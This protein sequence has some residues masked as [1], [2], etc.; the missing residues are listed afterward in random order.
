MAP[1]RYRRIPLRLTRLT[2]LCIAR[3][4]YQYGRSH[5][6]I[7]DWVGGSMIPYTSPNDP[8]FFFHHSQIEK[9]FSTWQ[10]NTN[11]FGSCYRPQ[12][13]DTTVNQSTPGVV[14]RNGQWRLPGHHYSDWMYPWQVRPRDVIGDPTL[15][16]RGYQ[17]A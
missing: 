17:F 1:Y 5:N 7:H 15:P 2:H 10:G 8:V 12:D 6:A 4:K 11:C 3:E 9:L 14:L 16:L 13:N